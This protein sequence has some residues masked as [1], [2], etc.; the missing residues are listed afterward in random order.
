MTFQRHWDSDDTILKLFLL[1]HTQQEWQV[2]ME[3]KQGTYK[4]TH[5]PQQRA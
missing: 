3:T 4:Q 2:T 5:A 1:K